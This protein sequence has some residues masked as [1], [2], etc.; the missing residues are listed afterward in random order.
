MRET[1]PE[2][3]Q[4]IQAF[5]QWVSLSETRRKGIGGSSHT[6]ACDFIP[7]SAVKRYLGANHRVEDLLSSLF[8][9]EASSI[10]AEVIRQHYLRP[11][12]ILL[13][14]GEGLMIKHFVHYP[15]LRD[16]HLPYGNRTKDFPLSSDPT[17]FERFSN[18]Q[19][20]FCAT[21]L[22]YNMDLHLH[23]EEILP[24]TDK[25]EI[26]HGGNAVIFK[27]NIHEEYNKLVPENHKMPVCR[28]FLELKF[29]W[30]I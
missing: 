21:D 13:L 23:E 24:I 17:F 19:W 20:R 11:L 1:Q 18:H 15:S 25:Q 26:G 10:D 14:I 5:H 30:L 9:K 12:A 8:G 16:N 7:R 28:Y 27:I 6:T 29:K 22:E 4:E 3:D 2:H